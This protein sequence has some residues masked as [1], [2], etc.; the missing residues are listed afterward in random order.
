MRGNSITT[1]KGH[2]HRLGEPRGSIIGQGSFE[3]KSSDDAQTMEGRCIWLDK[4]TCKV[5]G[6]DY[7]WSRS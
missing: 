1:L 6:S 4:F 5:E 3:V 2:Y 7:K